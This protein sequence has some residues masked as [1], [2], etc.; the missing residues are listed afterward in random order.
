MKLENNKK[1]KLKNKSYLEDLF[2]KKNKIKKEEYS[3]SCLDLGFGQTRQISKETREKN[4]I[5]KNI[6]N[7]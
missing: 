1:F 7:F 5:I 3:I 2:N 6:S 4:K